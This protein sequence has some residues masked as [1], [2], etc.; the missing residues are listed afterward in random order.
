MTSPIQASESNQ[1]QRKVNRF[2]GRK[3]AGVLIAGFGV[4]VAVNFYMAGL[5]I[6]GFH[7]VV[8][9]NSYVASQ[10]FNG[11]LEEAE[12]AEALGWDAHSVRDRA[13]YVVVTTQ[14]VPQG[15]VLAAELRR[16]LGTHEYAALTF[17]PLGEGRYRSNE[18]VADGRWTVRLLIQSGAQEWAQ[19]SELR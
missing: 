11:W 19:E 6:G 12:T 10:E 16:P 8:V 15:A 14:D 2:T 17:A 1:Q 9:E 3:M 13:G 5:A 18:Q 7:G 4:V